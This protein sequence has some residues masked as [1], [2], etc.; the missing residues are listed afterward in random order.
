MFSDRENLRER[1]M[2]KS[3]AAAVIAASAVTASCGHNR[4]QN[5]GPTVSRNYQVGNFQE[6]EVAGPFDVTVRTGANPGVSARGSQGLLDRTTVEVQGDKLVIRPK[7][8]HGFFNW[9]WGSHDKSG[10]TVT[11]PQLRAA[12]LA[13]A[14]DFNIDAV[15]GDSFDAKLA[16]SGDFGIGSVDVQSL[17]VTMAG[18]GDAKVGSGRA[19]NAEYSVVGSGDV[20]AAG[21]VSQQLKVN[22]AGSGGVKAHATGA[23]DISI[24]GSG[25]VDV[26]GGAKCSVSKAGSGDA[27]C[28]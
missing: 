24:M 6:I 2:R 20:D 14:G 21:V 22:I 8:R 26:S 25:D 28:S 1:K 10:F 4:A 5:D 16:G 7:D 15:R 3:I 18:A 11:V 27:H 23:A 9:S 19:Q 13:G 17:K 12:T